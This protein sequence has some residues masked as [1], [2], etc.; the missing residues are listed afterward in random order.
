[1]RRNENM[2]RLTTTALLMALAIILSRV[3]GLSTYLI[4]GG[5]QL[6]KISFGS[7]PILISG[8]ICGPF[9]GA[10]CGAGSDIIGSFINPAGAY[11]PGFTIDTMLFGLLPPLLLKLVK[12]QDIKEFFSSMILV[13]V[14]TIGLYANIPFVNQIKVGELKFEI[15]TLWTVLI[16]LIYLALFS[17]VSLVFFLLSKNR[18]KKEGFSFLDI[19][20][21]F[22]I[23]EFIITPYLASLWL[24][25]YYGIS[26]S[27]SFVNQLFVRGIQIIPFIIISY[28][29]M[30]PI[31]IVSRP[32]IASTYGEKKKIYSK[33]NGG[34]R[35]A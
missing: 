3:P 21:A 33:V 30:I 10:L 7:I 26:Y 13:A 32:L 8:L 9:Y 22:Y 11:F 28:L 2:I 15:N 23:K 31:S 19:S 16:P 12:G 24:Y 6:V 25:Y 27:F 29:I 4:I 1:M 20:L 5:V 14:C 35:L 18:K 17:V 34:K